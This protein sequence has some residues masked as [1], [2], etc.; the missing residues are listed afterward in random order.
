MYKLF[1]IHIVKETVVWFLCIAPLDCTSGVLCVFVDP[2]SLV[3][4]EA[5]RS[6]IHFVGAGSG[7]LVTKDLAASIGCNKRQ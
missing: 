2:V 3:R 7:V 1:T 4:L 6:G 5:V